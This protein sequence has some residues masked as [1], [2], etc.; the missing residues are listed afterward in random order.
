MTIFLQDMIPAMISSVEMMLEKWKNYE[1]KEIEVFG[2][3]R[4]LSSEVISRTAFG[5]SYIEGKKIFDMFQQLLLLACRNTYQ[6]SF[7]KLG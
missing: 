2:E 1:G 7:S 6:V 4:F 5:S 3:F